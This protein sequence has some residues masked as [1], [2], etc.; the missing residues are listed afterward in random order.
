MDIIALIEQFQRQ[1]TTMIEEFANELRRTHEA[2][3]T[4][5]TRKRQLQNVYILK[6]EG[7]TFSVRL[8]HK[9]GGKYLRGNIGTHEE[10]QRDA[11]YLDAAIEEVKAAAIREYLLDN[12][13]TVA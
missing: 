7:N 12:E 3:E 1:Q 5:R 4:Q 6:R 13:P 2:R 10:A 9:Y 11:K 8:Q